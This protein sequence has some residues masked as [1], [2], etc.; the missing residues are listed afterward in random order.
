MD[1][2]VHNAGIRHRHHQD[3]LVFP[4]L[5][6][7][8]WRWMPYSHV[9]FDFFSSPVSTSALWLICCLIV[10]SCFVLVLDCFALQE[11]LCV[12]IIAKSY[13]A[14]ISTFPRF[15]FSWLSL[16]SQF[17]YDFWIHLNKAISSLHSCILYVYYYVPQEK[18]EHWFSWLC[19]KFFWKMIWLSHLTRKLNTNAV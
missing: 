6:Q 18:T 12:R 11:T 7:F 16:L 5:S 4:F 15:L 8:P 2:V 10:F 13:P 1:C 14:L 9:C 19:C 17:V 3:V